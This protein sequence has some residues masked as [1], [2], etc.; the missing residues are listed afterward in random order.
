MGSTIVF[1]EHLNEYK[2]RLLQ[3][4]AKGGVFTLVTNANQIVPPGFGR[5]TTLGVESNTPAKDLESVPKLVFSLAMM[6]GNSRQEVKTAARISHLRFGGRYISWLKH[7]CNFFSD[8]LKAIDSSDSS[9]AVIWCEF[10]AKSRVFSAACKVRGIKV[11][12]LEYGFFSETLTASD[13][14]VGAHHVQKDQSLFWQIPIDQ[15]DIHKSEKLIE[16]IRSKHGVPPTAFAASKIDALNKPRKLL[17]LANNHPHS[18]IVDA[19][20]SRSRLQRANWADNYHAFESLV[21]IAAKFGIESTYRTHPLWP[22]VPKKKFDGTLVDVSESKTSVEAA[23]L[24]TDIVATINST[25]AITAV[26]L[27]KPVLLMGKLPIFSPEWI[28]ESPRKRDLEPSLKRVMFSYYSPPEDESNL[29]I[30]FARWLKAE[31]YACGG[32]TLGL[33]VNSLSTLADDLDKWANSCHGSLDAIKLN[34]SGV[35][36]ALS[37]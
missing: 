1:V 22:K 8:S 21:K 27:G 29:I 16:A 18:G 15:G 5:V 20:R 32:K 11:S 23:I 10:T 12:H 37:L 28:Y 17:F 31:V 6:S 7:W 35:S 24:H 33:Q 19:N 9:A 34:R 30:F 3:N 4:L 14:Q 36:N 26:I 2:N 13:A 25:A